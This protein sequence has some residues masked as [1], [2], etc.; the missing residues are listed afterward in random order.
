[1]L[2][3]TIITV[4]IALTFRSTTETQVTK[5]EEES[6]KALAAAEAALEKLLQQGSGTVTTGSISNI[7]AGFDYNAE[8]VTATAT[9]EF[10][11]PVVQQ[12]QIYSLYLADYDPATNAFSNY[13]NGTITVYYN[14][15]S[16]VNCNQF[17]IEA[18][19]VKG[20]PGSTSI[21]RYVGDTGDIFNSF[22]SSSNSGS[23]VSGGQ[24]IDG[25]T[26]YCRISAITV[27]SADKPHLLVVRNIS[28]NNYSTRFG[29]SGNTTLR[30]QGKTAESEASTT[31]GVTKKI[32]LFQS[33]P[34]LP[35][36][37]FVTQF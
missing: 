17:G 37:F 22:G 10:S 8:F 13:Y 2:L 32:Q 18:S 35:A 7:P 6:Q 24:T 21:S 28:P 31:T 15:T 33:Y 9:N 5:L 36:E 29:F 3:T 25:I 11:S 1:M 34:Q 26:Y 14:S 12:D 27:S 23:S 20:D 30:T 4:V 16:G 19:L